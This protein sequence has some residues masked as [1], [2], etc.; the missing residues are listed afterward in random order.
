MFFSSYNNI[1]VILTI[2]LFISSMKIE[3]SLTKLLDLATKPDTESIE[4]DDPLA[5]DEEGLLSSEIIRLRK[6]NATDHYV[7]TPDG[8][9]LNLVEAKNPLIMNSNDSTVSDDKEVIL[10]IHGIFTSARDFIVNSINARPKDYT[11]INVCNY[12]AKQLHNLMKNDPAR[13]TLVFT[14]LNFG[15]HVWVLNRRGTI[16]SRGHHLYRLNST[17]TPLN[18]VERIQK[19]AKD[20]SKEQRTNTA[21][22][23]K[24]IIKYLTS[25]FGFRHIDT[26]ESRKFWNYSLDEQ[27]RYDIPATIDYILKRTGRKNLTIIGHSIG[28]ALPLMSMTMHPDL[29]A[30]S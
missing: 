29:P 28:S 10:F 20:I 30:K 9:I 25:G 8:Y 19:L 24:S 1:I 3:I 22:G 14:A 18:D 4:E 7:T 27:A 12:S 16:E 21:S 11:H 17:T 6:F 26:K 15:H 23:L 2:L 5:H 13:K